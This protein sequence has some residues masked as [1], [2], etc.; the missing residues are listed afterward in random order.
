MTCLEL[1]MSLESSHF[2]KFVE[3][4]LLNDRAMLIAPQYQIR[5]LGIDR[6]PDVLGVHMKEKKFYL[7]E[8]SLNKNSRKL[9]SKI[10][11][12]WKDAT[13]IVQALKKEFGITHDGWSLMPMLFVH[14]DSLES[15]N[16]Q[17]DGLSCD[18]KSLQST[19][20]RRP[21]GSW[22]LD[23]TTWG[24]LAPAAHDTANTGER[25]A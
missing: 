14:E 7:I 17:L 3:E 24:K 8:I 25:L 4:Y 13:H 21:Q 9:K 22:R 19:M 2:E 23:D 12:Y 20:I 5:A 15:Y 10:E 18:V 6:Y 16:K 1:T 11:A